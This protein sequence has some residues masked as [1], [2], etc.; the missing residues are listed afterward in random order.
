MADQ[1]VDQL[2]GLSIAAGGTSSGSA[3]QP[4][5]VPD[6]QQPS[7]GHAADG[8]LAA[9][10][11]TAGGRGP[12][13]VARVAGAGEALAALR[14]LVGWPLLYAEQ[15]AQL[16]VRALGVHHRRA[17]CWPA[18]HRKG[19][20]CGR[21]HEALAAYSLCCCCCCCCCRSPGRAACSC[22][23]RPAAARR[24]WCRLWQASGL[25]GPGTPHAA[26]QKPCMARHAWESPCRWSHIDRFVCAEEFG[27]ALLSVTAGGVFGAYVGESER[28]LRDVFDQAVALAAGGQLVVVFLDEVSCRCCCRCPCRCGVLLLSPWLRCQWMRRALCRLPAAGPL[29]SCRLGCPAGGCAVPSAGGPAAA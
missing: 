15:A 21:Q 11:G 22:M 3:S 24:S 28:R 25:R 18:H 26:P 13:A 29:C 6:P 27:A 7:A 8:A 1:V 12:P 19:L 10:Q 16:G 9:E 20:S 23:G 4:T 14:E 5:G 17:H 2:A